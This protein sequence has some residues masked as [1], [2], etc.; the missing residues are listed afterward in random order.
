M[1]VASTAA[2]LEGFLKGSGTILLIDDELWEMVNSWVGQLEEELFVQALPLLRRTFSMFTHPERRKIGEKV[3]QGTG[4]KSTDL[5]SINN[6]DT[7]RAKKGIP[8]IMEL[9]GYSK[10]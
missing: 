9:F 2:W 10:A 4:K 8:I 7:E 5:K 3:K 6:F 1:P